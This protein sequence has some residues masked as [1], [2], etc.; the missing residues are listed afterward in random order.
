MRILVLFAHPALERSRVHRRLLTAPLGVSGVHLRDLYELYPDLDIDVAA[1]QAVLTEHDVVVFQHPLYW[2]SA[3]PIV[4]Q[5]QDLVLEHGW[6]YGRGGTALSGKLTFHV[7]SSG[8]SAEAYRPEGYNRYTIAELL[9]PFEQTA[10]LCR[11]EWLPPYAVHGT[12]RMTEPALEAH[13]ASYR[14]LLEAL[15]DERLDL[16]AARTSTSLHE[17]LERLL[18]SAG[19]A[20][21]GTSPEGPAEGARRGSE[22]REKDQAQETA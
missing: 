4:R 8:G 3:P 15:R 11:M 5:W 2:Y 22:P 1:E 18:E 7:L 16:P 17:D 20:S 10:R 12:H 6:A 21:V 19:P 14:R 9:R 13:V